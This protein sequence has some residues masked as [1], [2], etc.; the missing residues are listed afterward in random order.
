MFV[1][2]ARMFPTRSVNVSSETV[3]QVLDVY[4]VSVSVADV[5]VDKFVV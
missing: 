2:E 1:L 3:S 5:L 4:F